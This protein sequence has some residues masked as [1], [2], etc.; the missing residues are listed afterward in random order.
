MIISKIILSISIIFLF[1]ISAFAHTDYSDEVKE[2]KVYPIG[3]KIYQKMCTKNISFESYSNIQELKKSIKNDKLCKPLNDKNLDMLTIYLWDIKR[4]AKT[5]KTQ[6][7]IHVTKDEK[8]P[9]CGMFVYKY[10]KWATQIFYADKH[11]SFDG[12]KDMMKYYFKNRDNISKILVR[13]YY[14]QKAIDAAKAF[15]VI[16]SDI[17]GPMGNE[18]IPFADKNDADTFMMDHKAHEVLKF[19]EI[20][21]DKVN[22]LDE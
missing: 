8:C 21:N 7:H 4:V 1:D 18:L 3:K 16:G 11:Y 6:Q 12:V 14:S 13:D 17:Y 19:E 20:T 22:R 10:P 15:Y 2:K 5:E 9:I